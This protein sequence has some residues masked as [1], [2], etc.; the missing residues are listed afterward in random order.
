MRAVGVALTLLLV[1]LGLAV[2]APL[3]EQMPPWLPSDG[4]DLSALE[5]EWTGSWGSTTGLFDPNN[6]ISVLFDRSGNGVMEYRSG[7][8]RGRVRCTA[9][10]PVQPLD[11]MFSPRQAAT[12]GI[13]SCTIQRSDGGVQGF[14][15]AVKYTSQGVEFAG[16]YV[17]FNVPGLLTSMHLFR[18]QKPEPQPQPQPQPLPPP[19]QPQ[20]QPATKTGVTC[21]GA[22]LLLSCA[23]SGGRVRVT[24]VLYGRDDTLTCPAVAAKML[25]TS[26]RLATALGVV[27]SA[28]NG[29]SE[30]EVVASNQYLGADPC[31]GTRKFLRVVYACDP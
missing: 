23:Q 20:P 2:S 28:C 3:P 6:A 9:N 12:A 10:Q 15:G 24:D 26:C 17:H 14:V 29:K 1:G 30:C 8:P 18:T 31:V 21:E 13:M 5:G 27:Q 19:P 25:S 16:S 22:E 7:S 11:A 4:A